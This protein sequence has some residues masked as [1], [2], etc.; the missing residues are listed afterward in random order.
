[1]HLKSALILMHVDN[2][3]AARGPAVHSHLASWRVA[4]HQID[5]EHGIGAEPLQ[6][7]LAGVNLLQIFALQSVV[8]AVHY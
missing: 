3:K 2:R 7:P 5:C 6:G 4:V 1:L 8:A